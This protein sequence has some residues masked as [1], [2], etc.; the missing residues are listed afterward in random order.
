M[1]RR[2]R[3]E[4]I[5]TRPCHADPRSRRFGRCA[6]AGGGWFIGRA[7]QAEQENRR[8]TTTT[9]RFHIY[10]MST[11][12]RRAPVIP[13]SCSASSTRT[14]RRAL[15]WP[16]ASIEA[17][18]EGDC[19]KIAVGGRGGTAVLS[20]QAFPQNTEKRPISAALAGH[21]KL[22]R[23]SAAV[24]RAG[25]LRRTF[26]SYEWEREGDAQPEPRIQALSRSDPGLAIG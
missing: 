17:L 1:N 18:R 8:I 19:H 10:S 21:R 16:S 26:R 9:W 23:I 25:F 5:P 3:G 22:I 2:C 20:T 12:T 11:R 15:V 6:F 14:R 13:T 24:P 7:C 4:R